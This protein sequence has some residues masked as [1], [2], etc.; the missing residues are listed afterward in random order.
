MIAVLGPSIEATS[1]SSPESA[2]RVDHD[3]PEVL[4]HVSREICPDVA[5]DEEEGVAFHSWHYG[6]PAGLC[7]VEQ[8]FRDT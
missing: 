2:R 8:E 4:D 3:W 7:D 6:E 5:I 1:E